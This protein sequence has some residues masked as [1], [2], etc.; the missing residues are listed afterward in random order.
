MTTNVAH[1]DP[2]IILG[3]GTLGVAI[4]E[5][6]ARDNDTVLFLDPDLEAVES[7]TAL[8]ATAEVTDV[9]SGRALEAAVSDTDVFEL[10]I[11][12][13]Q[14]DA[15][16]LLIGQLAKTK[17][18]VSTVIVLM[19]DTRN[20]LAF[21]TAGMFPVCAPTALADA[22][23]ATYSLALLCDSD[24]PPGVAAPTSTINSLRPERPV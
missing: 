24:L 14:C 23:R 22:V 10:A 5:R 15:T 8:G 21:E 13:A 9:S 4:V 19:T 20:R 2:V 18:G 6:I 1:P 7:A 16:A 12:A 3:G 17:L 11:V